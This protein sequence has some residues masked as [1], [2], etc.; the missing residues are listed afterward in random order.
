MLLVLGRWQMDVRLERRLRAGWPGRHDVRA[1][2]RHPRALNPAQQAELKAAI[3]AA[4]SAAGVCQFVED[5][6]GMDRTGN[7]WLNY[8]HR[9]G[10]A[11]KRPK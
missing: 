4:P 10:F 1:H 2:G 9:L 6:F 3:Q 7:N 5:H 11:I 8:L